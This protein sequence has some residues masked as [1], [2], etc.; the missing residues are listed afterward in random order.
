MKLRQ[1]KWESIQR[2]P[3]PLLFSA[4]GSEGLQTY[5]TDHFEN[6]RANQTQIPGLPNHNA[7]RSDTDP[8][9]P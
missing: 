1:L 4:E 6:F 2:L 7:F 9:S 5:Q 8:P 3:N